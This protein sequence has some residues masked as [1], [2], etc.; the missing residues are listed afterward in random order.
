MEKK[1]EFVNIPQHE[2]PKLSII[3]ALESNISNDTQPQSAQATN[4]RQKTTT[5][6]ILNQCMMG[7]M[8]NNAKCNGNGILQAW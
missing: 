1:E 7:Y 6:T 8:H 5:Y 2:V 3:S 4:Q